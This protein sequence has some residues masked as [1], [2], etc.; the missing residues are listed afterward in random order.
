V[1]GTREK[2]FIAK[3]WTVLSAFPGIKYYAH[4]LETMLGIWPKRNFIMIMLSFV[5]WWF[6]KDF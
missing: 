6:S 5:G 2:Y 4:S 1:H 3:L